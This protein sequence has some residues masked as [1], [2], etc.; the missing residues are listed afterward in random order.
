[1]TTLLRVAPPAVAAT[2]L[3]LVMSGGPLAV[4]PR[5][6]A[7]ACLIAS[8]L[9]AIFVQR[10]DVR[11]HATVALAVGAF[12]ATGQ[13]RAGG[14]YALGATIFVGVVIVCLRVHRMPTEANASPMGTAS[15]RRA[16]LV[17]AASSFLMGGLLVWQLPRV[18]AIVEQ[19]VARWLGNLEAEEV[20]GFSSTMRLG[21]THGMLQSDRIVLRI[22]G[23]ASKVEYL[24]GAT[25]DRY[26]FG[27]WTSSTDAPPRTILPATLAPAQATT[28]IVHA[29]NAR[30][31][32][33]TDARWFLPAGACE[34]G[35]PNGK[36]AIDRGAVAHPDAVL[37]APA[38]WF[39]MVDHPEDCPT[40]PPAAAPPGPL[41]LELDPNIAFDIKRIAA[42][43]TAGAP[44][45]R[46]KL[47]NIEQR[48]QSFGYSLDVRRNAHYDAIIDFLR[49][50]REGHCELFASAMALLARSSG[51]PARVVTG[52]RGGD[53]NRVGN[54]TVVRERNAHAW[55]EA[56]VDGKW[57]TF[58]PTPPIEG[59]R[60]EPDTFAASLDV[61][62]YAFD[63][64]II[65]LGAI[66]LLQWGIG[67]GVLAAVL[68]AIREVTRRLARVR[69][70]GA[71]SI[72]GEYD[73]ALPAFDALTD[74]LADAG[75]PRSASE[76]IESFARRLVALDVPWS[77]AA[78]DAL[79]R[80]A[81]LRYGD[82]GEPTDVVGAL[83]QAAAAARRVT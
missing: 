17:L 35:T 71:K 64:A 74:A 20:T 33:G 19:R 72:F 11:T 22:E 67:L 60:R 52:Y 45:E 8:V 59:M 78:A 61:A 55:V 66:T 69:A 32:L 47:A 81:A 12:V 14:R 50:H 40:P 26:Y 65:A 28:R 80:Y 23:D 5:T 53:V 3:A 18:G 13:I 42:E 9:A 68:Y 77:R 51:I 1:M 6:L 24:R 38:I 49:L 10:P 79:A 83:E 31:A 37:D 2:M 62:N 43:W 15:R 56:W 57:R 27:E 54:Y 4:A 16:A 30:V 63:R 76:P 36:I 34:L 41:D 58:D 73:A 46:A 70:R 29:R 39:R 7:I 21:S 75:H 82:R 48:L 44:D 25:Y